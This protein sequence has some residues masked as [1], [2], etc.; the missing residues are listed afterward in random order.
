MFTCR[1]TQVT[2]YART[3]FLA[4]DLKR[5]SPLRHISLHQETMATLSWSEHDGGLFCGLTKGYTRP[6]PAGGPARAFLFD[7]DHTLIA[8]R[9]GRVHPDTRSDWKWWHDDVPDRLRALADE[10]R[11]LLVVVTNQSGAAAEPRRA[12]LLGR[13]ENVCRELG[14]PLCVLVATADSAH[15]KPQTGAWRFFTRVVVEH[16]L[17]YL[18]VG[19]AAGRPA[20]W[21]PR[22]KKDFSDSDRKCAVN[23]G[24]PFKTPEEFFLGTPPATL[25]PLPDWGA[26]LDAQPEQDVGA[27]GSRD[28]QQEVVVLVGQPA[29]GKSSLAAR[30]FAPAGYTVVSRDELGTAPRVLKAV[31]SALSS[32]DAVV[33]D[34]TNPTVAARK[35]FVDAARAAG[36]PVR[37]L[38]VATDP[39][40]AAH[41]NGF[42]AATTGKHVPQV[43]INTYA[44]KYTPPSMGEGFDAVHVVVP[45][46]AVPAELR[47]AFCTH[48]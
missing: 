38:V 27:W 14:V 17:P 22:K 46:V 13:I 34:N 25:P 15:R 43:A 33:V 5:G 35:P 26:W 4:S 29:S 48:Y 8:T 37:A 41:L 16:A 36:V 44:S 6:D 3:I 12:L 28:G 20:G 40:V 42:R 23:L 18:F 39:A 21:A 9:S 47:P 19:D 45:P 32:G 1:H 2:L 11:T 30:V 24:C 10:P 31:R 7:L